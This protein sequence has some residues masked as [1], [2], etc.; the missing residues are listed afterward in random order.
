MCEHWFSILRLA[1]WILLGGGWISPATGIAASPGTYCNPL[2]VP[3]YPLG[4][5]CRFK[6]GEKIDI[7]QFRELADPTVLW[8]QGQWILYPSC[9]M[10]WTSRDGVSWEHHPL[11]VRDIG[12]APTVVRYGKR[13]LLTACGA[14]LYESDSALGPFR[15]LGPILTPD[16]RKPVRWIDPMLFADDDGKLYL[17]WGCGKPGIFVVELDQQNPT[18][19]KSEPRAAFAFD[20][21][22]EWERSGVWN[23]DSTHNW[24][25][26]S[27]L[28]KHG[29]RYYLTYA[30][31]GTQ[32]RTYG[33]GCYVADHPLG[34]YRPQKLNPILRQTT[35]LINGPGHG[36]IVPGPGKIGRAHV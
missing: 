33:M 9:D 13:F 8:E 36:C 19:M 2:S 17:T 27:W 15:E 3:N 11:N 20:P 1:G 6:P 32:W 7:K 22:H 16:G 18:R 25:E 35:G 5:L 28:L 10:A 12:Y 34:P 21:S 30:T 26:G 31:P 4:E 29:G 14:S 24:N 23:E